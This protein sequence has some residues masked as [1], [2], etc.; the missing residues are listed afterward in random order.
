[1]LPAKFEYVIY[2]NNGRLKKSGRKG[3]RVKTNYDKN[4][5]LKSFILLFQSYFIFKV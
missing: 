4:I 3:N 1:M 5:L 2:L